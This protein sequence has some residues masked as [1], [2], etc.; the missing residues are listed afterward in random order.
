[1]SFFEI[2]TMMGLLYFKNECC[3]YAVLEVGL[4]GTIDATNIV[5]PIMTC[6]TSIG[7][8]HMEVLGNTLEE[9]ASHKAG[10]IKPK[11]PVVV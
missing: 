5:R 3:D 9:I 8:D 10:I 2:T 7:F 1:M 6:I 11:I 4:G